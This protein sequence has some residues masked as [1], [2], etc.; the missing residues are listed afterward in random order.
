MK[1]IWIKS[2][3]EMRNEKRKNISMKFVEKNKEVVALRTPQYRQPP[4]DFLTY[5][6]KPTGTRPEYSL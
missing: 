3:S 1:R 2:M 4:N 6:P 5:S